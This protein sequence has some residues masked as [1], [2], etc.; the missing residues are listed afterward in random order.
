MKYKSR[1]PY[2]GRR[3]ER[4]VKLQKALDI[5]WGMTPAADGEGGGCWCVCVLSYGVLW[6]EPSGSTRSHTSLVAITICDINCHNLP[7]ILHIHA[8]IHI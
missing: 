2:I 1:S 3:D 7:Y 6:N 5:F 4:S 8:C